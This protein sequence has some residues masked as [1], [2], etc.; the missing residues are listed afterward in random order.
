MDSYLL[1]YSAANKEEAKKACL[2]IL[3]VSGDMDISLQAVGERSGLTGWIWKKGETTFRLLAPKVK[4]GEKS[5]FSQENI[6]RAITWNMLT[7][8]GIDF[9][10][11]EVAEKE[12]HLEVT[13]DTE[14]S[15]KI[16]GKHGRV[17]DA[18]QFF[19]NLFSSK[20]FNAGLR[21]VLEVA[22]YRKRRTQAVTSLAKR[23]ASQVAEEKRSVSLSY[24]NPYER[25]VVHITLEDDHRVY[26]ESEGEGVY[27]RVGIF[28][29]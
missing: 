27:K 12:G 9:E 26:T 4:E 22:E 14:D 1:E 13:I 7:N 6:I 16:I 25:R 5:P 8:F 21:V 3:G 23:M 18:L 19:A 20:Y 29:K 15:A 24:M 28:P 10:L 11:V 2:E 17:L